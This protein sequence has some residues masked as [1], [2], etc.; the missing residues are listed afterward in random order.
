MAALTHRRLRAPSEDGAALIDPP[1]NHADKLIAKNRA[2]AQQWDQQAGVPFSQW[3]SIARADLVEICNAHARANSELFGRLEPQ[4]RTAT[5]NQPFV[6]SG[7]QPTLFHPGVWL[8]NYLLS[9]IAQR[10]GANAINLVIDNDVVSSPGITVP[11]GTGAELSLVQVP[12]DKPTEA[13]PW[14]SRTI[15]DSDLFNTFASRVNEAYT[16]R[17]RSQGALLLENLW[18]YALREKE[19]Q[20]EER[21]SIGPP[22]MNLGDCL[23]T[24]RHRTE[25][26][27]GLRTYEAPM[28]LLVGHPFRD[29]ADHLFSRAGELREIYNAALHEYRL[30]NR[31]RSRS[32]PVP[33]LDRDGEWIEV[34]FW[35]WTNDSPRRKRAFVR[36][37]PAG[38]ELIDR[39]GLVLPLGW[40]ASD[41]PH[42]D[43]STRLRP[44]ALITTMY[45]RLVL[46]DLFIHGIGGAKYDELTDLI[47]RR[48]FGIEP[49]S[50]VT[51]TATFRLPI[52][53]PHVSLADVQQSAQ[54]IRE[55]RYRPE[56]LLDEPAVN[57]DGDIAAKLTALAAEKR[58]YLDQHDLRRCSSDVFNRL[59]ALN[60][61]MHHL[62]QP[63]EQDLRARHTELVTLARQSQLLGSREF[64]FVLF[65]AE[66]LSAQLLAL[67]KT[68]S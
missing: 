66:K 9:A 24:A 13:V 28:H 25:L 55:I 51:A 2:S 19:S 10:S 35:L 4:L 61:A 68:I 27:I 39:E 29:F 48:F 5:I 17:N 16:L 32:H 11:T 15:Q 53:R 54:R 3:R 34:P 67:S 49:P 57:K 65:P 43:A 6:L 62:L 59:D 64:S 63:M 44:R 7:H 52:E 30:V 40:T 47:I 58:A 8:K 14:E 37:L 38:C 21:G 12:I 26:E 23:A 1:A 36:K 20:L 31:I 22:M 50:Y 60:R 46:S 42:G 45:A 56:S 33:E 18:E 41:Q